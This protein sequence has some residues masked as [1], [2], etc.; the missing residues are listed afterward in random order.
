MSRHYLGLSCENT[1]DSLFSPYAPKN[2]N[3]ILDLLRQ[4]IY[5]KAIILI[6]R[7]FMKKIISVLLSAFL[8]LSAAACGGSQ[9]EAVTTPGESSVTTQASETETISEESITEATLSGD[10]I[11]EANTM[12]DIT[13]MELVKEM[14]YGINLGNTFEACGDWINSE[15]AD[16]YIKAWGSPIIT[17]EIIETYAGAGF[18]VL[19]IPVAWSNMMEKDGTYTISPE[20]MARVKEAVDWTLESGMYA[21][22]NIHWDSGWLNSLPDDVEGTI[23][24]FTIMW[25]QIAKA[26]EDY[27][28]KLMFECQNEELGWES[29]WNPWSGKE[30]EKKES[31][32]LANRVNQVFVDTIRSGGGNNPLRHLLISGYNTDIDRT[33]DPLFEMPE[34]PAGRMAISVHYYTPSTLC[35]LDKDASWGKARTEWGNEKDIAELNKY[36][37]MLKETFIDKGIPVIVGEYGCFGNNKEREV[38]ENW[39]L[40]V[41]KAMYEI[42]ACPV[43]WDTPG[44]ECD[45]ANAVFRDPEFIEELIKPWKSSN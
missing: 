2:G 6:R 14:G 9:Q 15:S 20:Y 39:T 32:A 40:T 35:I 3:I 42:G 11:P 33:C 5:N 27:P 17:K 10:S 43:L 34:D 21:I 26:F 45:R 29:I 8:I 44:D 36:M 28:D 13:T 37:N 25:T 16:N 24:R 22:I 41:S 7:T 31:F 38:K 18:G 12:R 30:D 23:D 1:R 19:R 4:R